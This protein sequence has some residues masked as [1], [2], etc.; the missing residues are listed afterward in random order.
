[1]EQLKLLCELNAPSGRENAVRN[2][3]IEQIKDKADIKVDALG[4]VVAFVRGKKRTDKKI[5]V[6]AH[7]DEVGFIVTYITAD[8]ILKFTTVGGIN[9][10]VMLARRVEFSN[11]VKGVIGMKPV[12]MLSSAEKDKMP[13][14]DALYID[15][16]ANSKEEAEGLV[17]VG[18]CAVF[19]EPYEK[20]GDLI[21]SKAID[22]RAGCWAI[23]D[24]INSEP[25]YDF[26]ASF[27][28]NEEIGAGARTAAYSIGPDFA[29]VVESTTAADIAGVGDDRKVCF[30]GQ[31]AVISFMDRGTLYN[32]R[33][34]DETLK[35]AREKDIKAQVKAYVSGGNNAAGIHQS[36]GGVKTVAVSVPC[37]YIHSASSAASVEDIKSVRALVEQLICAMASGEISD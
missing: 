37:R 5:M 19:S 6:D 21:L 26:Y 20:M 16:G 30:V 17:S 22:D 23:L 34:F 2:Y 32:K 33:L 15:I 24:I 1:M 29:I 10:A 12:H 31:G 18:D 28:V 36:R 7:M 4:N 13:D 11:G 27:S 25:E 9:T 14:T 8:G 35:L 3:I